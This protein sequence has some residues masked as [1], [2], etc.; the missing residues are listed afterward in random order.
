MVNRQ[1]TKSR[2]SES[3]ESNNEFLSSEV[4]ELTR[5]IKI[6]ALR[7]PLSSVEASLEPLRRRTGTRSSRTPP[8]GVTGTR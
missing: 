3:P 1:A 5:Q 4:A 8:E 2:S 7:R 6:A